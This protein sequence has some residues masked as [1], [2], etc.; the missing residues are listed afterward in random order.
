MKNK[1]YEKFGGGWG[2]GAQMRCSMADLQVT[3]NFEA[4]SRAYSSVITVLRCTD[5]KGFL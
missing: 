3:F 5:F 1:G 4:A 2:G